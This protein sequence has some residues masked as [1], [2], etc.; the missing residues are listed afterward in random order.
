M[1]IEI[2]SV[3]DHGIAY[4]VYFLDPD[5]HH[6]EVLYQRFSDDSESKSEFARIGAVANPVNIDEVKA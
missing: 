1:C 2:L 4:G 5:G 3:V 6:I